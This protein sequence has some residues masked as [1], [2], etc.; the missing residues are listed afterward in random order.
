MNTGTR[1][2]KPGRVM[3]PNVV[4][5]VRTLSQGQ[6]LKG[7]ASWLLTNLLTKDIVLVDRLAIQMPANYTEHNEGELKEIVSNAMYK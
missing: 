6:K 3:Q 2:G 5:P 7:Y 4:L 1:R